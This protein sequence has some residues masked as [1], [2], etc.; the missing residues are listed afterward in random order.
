MGFVKCLDNGDFV[1]GLPR[2]SWPL[3]VF[4][5]FDSEHTFKRGGKTSP[6]R[7]AMMRDILRLQ[8]TSEGRFCAR[9][10]ISRQLRQRTD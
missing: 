3:E 9:P 2:V 7:V 5:G 4:F 1:G 10:T 8:R 6:G